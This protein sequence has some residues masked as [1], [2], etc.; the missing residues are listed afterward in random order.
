MDL[1]KLSDAELIALRN[2]DL[3]QISNETLNALKEAEIERSAKTVDEMHPDISF[4]D[5]AI[6]KN[7][8]ANPEATIGYL[9]KQHPDMVFHNKDGTIRMRRQGEQ[10]YRV[11]DPSGFD[12]QDITDVGSDIAQGVGEGVAAAYTGISTL[13]PVAG[14]A[15][16]G[17][18][19]GASESAKQGV[20][21]MLGIPNNFDGTN[22]AL[23][24]VA[25][26]AAPVIGDSV[27]K[28][29]NVTKNTIA[30]NVASYLSGIDADI[31]R[32]VNVD[33]QARKLINNTGIERFLDNK[34][35]VI[36]NALTNKQNQ[37]G[38][39]VENATGNQVNLRNAKDQVFDLLNSPTSKLTPFQQQEASVVGKHF[40]GLIPD[41]AG[42]I[43][44]TP[45]QVRSIRNSMHDFIG[46]PNA[47]YSQGEV[48]GQGYAALRKAL[49]DSAPD[50]QAFNNANDEFSNY[51]T[52]RNSNS[53][54]KTF[55]SDSGFANDESKKLEQML[56]NNYKKYNSNQMA[57]K[58]ALDE[59]YGFIQNSGG[60]DMKKMSR[61]VNS[62]NIFNDPKVLPKDFITGAKAG[63]LGSAAGG[64]LAY[65]TGGGYASAIP[66]MLGGGVAGEMAASPY[67]IK[68]V[69]QKSLSAETALNGM[70]NSL[71]GI[72][73]YIRK[74]APKSLYNLMDSRED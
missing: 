26:G 33:D 23:S 13:N 73:P 11:L 72:S 59:A 6:V 10:D 31:I 66:L 52:K 34:S 1:S 62:F 30:P 16:M 67:V 43:I 12:L 41:Q 4:A 28:G 35:K 38:K 22:I 3:S 68:K 71:D 44:T 29:W 45:D 47:T 61:E 8:A 55:V 7:F 69:A 9:Q 27:K 57:D 36:S 70:A 49:E 40:D 17:A 54:L 42:D 2:G 63:G 53:N 20:G 56:L 5:R 14:Y 39:N 19:G 64:G 15:A 24:T 32:N 50:K 18:L 37:L 46:K 65:L 60:P 51:L 58:H 48:A 74:S 21:T 25:S